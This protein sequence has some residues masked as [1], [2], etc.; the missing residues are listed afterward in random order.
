MTTTET[1]IMLADLDE[2]PREFV[3][4]SLDPT[5]LDLPSVPKSEVKKAML[6]RKSITRPLRIATFEC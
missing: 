4:T 5:N 1:H 2:L 6:E 3:G